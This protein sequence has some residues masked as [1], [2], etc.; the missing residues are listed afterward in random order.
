MAY[1]CN[2]LSHKKLSSED[3][4]ISSIPY[5]DEIFVYKYLENNHTMELHDRA[6]KA[7]K[8]IKDAIFIEV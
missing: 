6:N 2:E 4:G 5:N 3:L 7:A 1:L 8:K